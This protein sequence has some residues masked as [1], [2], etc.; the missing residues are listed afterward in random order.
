[1][2]EPFENLLTQGMVIKDGAKMSKSKGN[3]VDPDD[4]IEKYGA[5]TT[6]LFCLF[7]S[8]PEK[9]L[10]WSDQGIEGCY[11]FLNRLYRMVEEYAEVLRGRVPLY[12]VE[13][14]EGEDLSLVVRLAKTVKK[15]TEDMERAHFNTAI[16]AIMEFVNFLTRYGE[17]V[18]TE[19]SLCLFRG[20]LERVIKLLAPF[21]PHIAYELWA[22]LGNDAELLEQDWPGYNER[23]LKEER[24][25][26]VVEVNG[27]VRERIEVDR[28]TD[29]ETLKEMV[30]CLEKVR[31]HTDGRPIKKIVTIP[32]KLINIVCE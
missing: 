17:N 18:R 13:G 31:R 7:A 22:R 8:P 11:R 28:D 26:I 23:F 6:R 30:L 15:V 1:V 16:A 14:E 21:V 27:K 9:D 5:D 25:L 24:V 19:R 29:E 3:V 10:E 32:N 4:M 12:E 2:E 20:A